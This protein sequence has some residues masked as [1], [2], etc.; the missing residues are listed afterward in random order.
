MTNLLEELHADLYR[1]AALFGPSHG[2]TDKEAVCALLKGNAGYCMEDSTV[3]PYRPGAVSLPGSSKDAPFCE[4]L[5]DTPQR[6]ML[7]GLCS[8]Y[9]RPD[10]E[11]SVLEEVRPY[12]DKVLEHDRLAYRSFLKELEHR[13]LVE[14]RRRCRSKVAV[15]F[16]KKKDGQLR[17]V[18]DCRG[19]NQLFL[20]PP[21]V[22]LTTSES[23]CR[24]EMD[25]SDYVFISKVDVQNCFY[26]MLIEGELVEYF[27]LPA[28]SEAELGVG[29]FIFRGE[30]EPDTAW[31][32]CLKA[33]PMGF[34]WSLFFAQHAIS[35][36]VDRAAEG[37]PRLDSPH[38]V[39]S[40]GPECPI[41]TYTYVDNVGVVGTDGKTVLD[42][43]TGIT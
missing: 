35:H 19:T 24:I 17:M 29:D 9:L 16:V 21:A 41:S 10:S 39:V 23:M 42:T 8:D 13:G 14:W 20:P 6:E 5:L 37:L 11:T 12:M 34:S 28:M 7:K 22:G 36:Q 40:L 27:A 38:T 4:D 2:L 25:S 32:P 26:Q 31:Y 30:D 1:S 33:L 15:F 18:L 43:R 3:A